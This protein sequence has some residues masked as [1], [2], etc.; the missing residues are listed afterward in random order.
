MVHFE[1]AL[2]P[3]T[4][5]SERKVG[6]RAE[7]LPPDA[8]VLPGDVAFRLHDTYGFPIDLTVELA[9]EYGVRV[10]REGFEREL[11]AQRE[12]SRGGRKADM[13]RHAEMTGLY[14]EIASRA[15][16]TQFLGYETVS[17]EGHVVAILRDGTEY[18]DL[19]AKAEAE[20][21]VPAGAEAEIV[22]DQTP[23]YAEGG[24]Q[25]G[26]QGVLR[27][28]DGELLFTVKDTQR[29]VPGLIV[30]RG[31]LH[32]RLAVGDVVVAEVDP[33]RR[34][35]TMRNHTATHLLH[36]ALRNTVG[37][38]ARQAGS[39]VTPDYLRF[40]FPLR[41]GPDHRREAGDRGGGAPSRPREQD[42]DARV[43]CRWPKP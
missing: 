7:D 25:V 5:V 2:I 24:G 41:P 20:L 39:L 12:R 38:R 23:F 9:A 3:L 35:R 32:G 17:A 26:D 19:E 1:E 11:A 42:G 8:P 13:A 10:D 29:P 40:D 4:S 14:Q 37:E 28:A 15:G 36:R 18:E 43:S 21:R 34:A 30:H 33:E 31:T 6:R 16:D 27:A 22:L